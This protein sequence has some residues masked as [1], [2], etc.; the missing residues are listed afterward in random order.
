MYSK[1]FGIFEFVKDPNITF[2]SILVSFQ[3]GH[4]DKIIFHFKQ[5]YKATHHLDANLHDQINMRKLVII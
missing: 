1:I 2:T 5:I 3:I 4:K